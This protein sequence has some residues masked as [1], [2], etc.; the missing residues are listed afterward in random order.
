MSAKSR[1]TDSNVAARWTYEAAVRV[2][3][4]DSVGD[5]KVFEGPDPEVF[6]VFWNPD[7]RP[8]GPIF[9][10]GEG[11]RVALGPGLPRRTRRRKAVPLETLLR[12]VSES[13]EER[14]ALL[15]RISEMAGGAAPQSPDGWVQWGVGRVEISVTN[16][17]VQLWD[18]SV[19]PMADATAGAGW[20]F[21]PNQY[22][23]VFKATFTVTVSNTVKTNAPPPYP[24]NDTE[25]IAVNVTAQTI[26]S[27]P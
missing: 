12:D 5:G 8:Q 6:Q 10:A 4:T 7:Y 20:T 17:H 1:A 24:P 15:H 26:F 18:L 2:T 27:P 3:C 13:A 9:F 19:V 22:G 21:D 23:L 16:G 11:G 25:D 14:D